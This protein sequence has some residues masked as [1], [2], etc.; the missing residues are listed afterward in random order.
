MSP[1]SGS[2]S[3]SDP[4]CPANSQPAEGSPD[5]RDGSDARDGLDGRTS[6]VVVARVLEVLP[7]PNAEQI[8]LAILDLGDG[9]KRQVVFGGTRELFP[10]DLVPAAPPG[11]RVPGKNKKMRR[12]SY[13]GQSSFGMLCSSD[14][15]GWTRG[16]PNAVAVLEGDYWVGQSLDDYAG[17]IAWGCTRSSYEDD[18][19]VIGSI[20]PGAPENLCGY[21]LPSTRDDDYAV[22]VTTTQP[23]A[24]W[25]HSFSRDYLAQF[26]EGDVDPGNQALLGFYAKVYADLAGRSVLEFGGGPTIYSL[27]TAARTAG[28]IHFCDYNQAC[29]DEVNLWRNNDAT[30]F[31]W[32]KFIAYALQCEKNVEE[33]QSSAEI[34]QRADLL[35]ERMRQVSRCDIFS[36]D[37][38]PGSSWGQYGVVANTFCLDSIIND[39]AQWV[40]LNR[41]L[42]VMVEPDG[43]YV[44]VSLLNATHWT[45]GGVTHPA[46]ALTREDVVDMYAELGL[47]LTYCDV[48]GSLSGKKGYEGFIMACGRR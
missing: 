10:G 22:P 3:D 24:Q 39:K 11:A 29:L 46:V 34:V 1:S 43:L 28:S 8:R 45:T 42:A 35:R 9:A 38:L 40:D 44:T 33:Y 31:D 23:A 47:E 37:P 16:G 13:R 2:A 5:A 14:E 21:C 36:D 30:A 26:Y 17:P 25:C 18:E 27:I 7:H 15:L 19:G 32:T 4:L 20:C 41:K 48:T 12:R 6:G